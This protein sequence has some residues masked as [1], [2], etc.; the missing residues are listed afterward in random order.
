MWSHRRHMVDNRTEGQSCNR[1][2]EI[3]YGGDDVYS[4][5]IVVHVFEREPD[6]D[7]GEGPVDKVEE[8]PWDLPIV[9]PSAPIL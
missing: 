6:F 2:K 8:D 7:N 1:E 4:R 3:Y 5:E 9:R